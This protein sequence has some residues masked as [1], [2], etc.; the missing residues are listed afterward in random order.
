M[1]AVESFLALR[2]LATPHSIIQVKDV[3]FDLIAQSVLGQVG[4]L[5]HVKDCGWISVAPLDHHL[6][7]RVQVGR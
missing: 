5:Q 6:Y 2:V 4:P 7:R 3:G 1:M